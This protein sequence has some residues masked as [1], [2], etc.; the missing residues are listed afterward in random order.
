M[1]RLFH[2]F[3]FEVEKEFSLQYLN[4][5]LMRTGIILAFILMTFYS[6]MDLFM[7][8]ETKL[9]AL[10]IR[11]VV[12]FPVV[13]ILIFSFFPIFRNVY[14]SYVMATLLIVSFGIILM[15][16][17]SKKNEPGY[18]YYFVGL[19]I[20]ISFIGLF[21]ELRFQHSFIVIFLIIFGY[22]CVAIFNQHM[23][24][25]FQNNSDFPVFLMSTVSLV[26]SGVLSLFATF[27]FEKYRRTT[28]WQRKEIELEKAKSEILLQNI[29]P[30]EVATELKETGSAKA[31]NFA[32][33]TVLFT[34][35]KNFTAFA[36]KLSAQELVNEINYYYSAFDNIISK[37]G[38][39]KI[40]TIGD[41]YMCAGGLTVVS[42]T[43]V[44]DTLNA[45]IEIREFVLN[46]KQKRILQEKMFFEIRIGIHS[47]PV[48]AG[49][50]GTKKF[51]YDIW[52]DTVNIASRM[53]SSGEPGK[54][55][56][57]GTTYELIKDKFSCTYR[58]KIQAKN[59][60]M[61]EMY[62]VEN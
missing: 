5:D 6:V 33:A 52:G 32:T 46:E 25:Q 26:A 18:Y 48:V 35:F 59:K 39:E 27:L 34:D 31:K 30:P 4:T 16:Y 21:S 47:G 42:N 10:T 17:H 13:A 56:I 15:I 20:V 36:E 1:K 11:F 29:L 7:L 24:T 55:N 57:S 62:F 61:I 51:A 22:L 41:S 45:G 23:L 14:T 12:L 28:F 60:G 49:I 2:K 9:I 19:M 58:G 37:Y 8:P 44:E 43:S 54:V 40:K 3:E 53:E 50:V 38:I